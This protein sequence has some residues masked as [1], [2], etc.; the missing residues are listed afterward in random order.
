[1]D[2]SML[3][4]L[5]TIVTLIVAIIM[6]IM[7]LVGHHSVFRLSLLRVNLDSSTTV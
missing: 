4:P 6:L 1:M 3:S 2:N 5:A 7:A